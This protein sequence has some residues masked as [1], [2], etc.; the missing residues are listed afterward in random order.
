M[1]DKNLN[2]S[3]IKSQIQVAIKTKDKSDTEE[4]LSKIGKYR[5]VSQEQL[6]ILSNKLSNGL[7]D[8]ISLSTS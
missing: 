4:L 8:I 3:K 6:K 7:Y 1:S 2:I 5:D